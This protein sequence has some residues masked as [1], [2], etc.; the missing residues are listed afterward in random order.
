MITTDG[1]IL[2]HAA[3]FNASRKNT[4]SPHRAAIALRDHIREVQDIAFKRGLNYVVVTDNAF[5]DVPWIDYMLSSYIDDGLPLR[6]AYRGGWM[7]IA[8]VVD[9]TKDCRLCVTSG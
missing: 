3:E 6:H 7:P 2:A 8:N 4:V 9:I 5:Y 1:A